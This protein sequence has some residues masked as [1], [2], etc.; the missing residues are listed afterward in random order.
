MLRGS[1]RIWFLIA[2]AP[3]LLLLSLGNQLGDLGVGSYRLHEND[4]VGVEIHAVGPVQ[5]FAAL[6]QDVL[7]LLGRRVA[8]GQDVK[9]ICEHWV[10][11]SISGELPKVD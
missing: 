5:L 6:H 7:D 4:A 8:L 2:D 3:L 9:D 1:T 10:R 11:S